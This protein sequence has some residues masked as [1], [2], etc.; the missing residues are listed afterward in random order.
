MSEEEFAVVQKPE[1]D[2]KKLEDPNLQADSQAYEKP[3]EQP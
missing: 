1:T 3:I 2:P